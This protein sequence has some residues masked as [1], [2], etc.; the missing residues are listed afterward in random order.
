M[1]SS[2]SRKGESKAQESGRM[3]D[4]ESWGLGMTAALSCEK[5]SCIDVSSTG[6]SLRK[7]N[8]VCR[9]VSDSQ[10]ISGSFGSRDQ[11][12]PANCVAASRTTADRRYSNNAHLQLEAS[13]KGALPRLGAE[14][15]Y[16]IRSLTYKRRQTS[17]RKNQNDTPFHCR[18]WNFGIGSVCLPIPKFRCHTVRVASERS[19]IQRKCGLS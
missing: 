2:H 6:T 4:I 1:A 8:A 18:L 11:G 10:S 17:G 19:C 7:C 16:S 12:Y 9:Q 13:L 15:T 3:L 14:W 5:A